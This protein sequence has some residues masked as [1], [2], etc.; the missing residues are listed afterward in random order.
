LSYDIIWMSLRKEVSMKHLFKCLFILCLIFLLGGCLNTAR[1]PYNEVG[2]F[3]ILHTIIIVL[4]IPKIIISSN[5]NKNNII[6]ILYNILF[7]LLF[8]FLI[9]KNISIS[10]NIIEI[11]NNIQDVILY[12]NILI[13]CKLFIIT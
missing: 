7:N 5:T 10:I 1:T 3:S 13:P 4:I 11:I 9:K 6:V 2:L 8:T 12:E